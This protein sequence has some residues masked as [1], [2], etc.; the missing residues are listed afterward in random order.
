MIKT[1]KKNN[2]LNNPA[3]VAAVASSPQGQDAIKTAMHAQTKAVDLGFQLLK[4]G[5][6]IG[7]VYYGYKK[8]TNRFKK[9]SY[10]PQF[11]ISN[12]S[13]GQAKGKA[14]AIKGADGILSNDFDIVKEQFIGVN[15]NGLV[16]IYNAF[17]HEKATAFLGDDMDMFG[18]L[19]E[20]FSTNQM[21]QLDFL[22][23]GEFF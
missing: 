20:K 14:D 13:D 21:T 8:F 19:A 3:A 1:A 2:G 17:G 4:Y 11:P 22:T 6:I 23:G 9:M 18:W 7:G 5:L 15:T 12:I 16:K 10:F